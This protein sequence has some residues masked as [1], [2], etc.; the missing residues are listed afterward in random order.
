MSLPDVTNGVFDQRVRLSP[1]TKALRRRFS[2][3]RDS[4]AER[5]AGRPVTRPTQ[6]RT[7]EAT[8]PAALRA[9]PNTPRV[10]GFTV[11]SNSVDILASISLSSTTAIG[12]EANTATAMP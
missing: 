3:A 7:A 12:L 9:N 8:A 1:R 2:A 4:R 10:R 6:P 11:D 5:A